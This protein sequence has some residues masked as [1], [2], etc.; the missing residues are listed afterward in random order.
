LESVW[1]CPKVVSAIIQKITD[2]VI[3]QILLSV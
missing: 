1:L 2:N 3:T